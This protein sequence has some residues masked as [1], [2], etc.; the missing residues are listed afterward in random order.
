MTLRAPAIALGALA[1][2]AVAAC[3]NGGGLGSI[4]GSSSG[5]PSPLPSSAIGVAIPTGKI[6]VENDPVWGTVSGYT[7]DQTS[8]VL[9]FAPGAKVT[10]RNLSSTTPHTLNVIGTTNGPPPHWPASP[11]LPFSPR[12]N[13]ILGA[14]YA[15]GSLNPGASVTVTLSNPGIYLIGC[16]YHYI[17]FKMRDIIEVVAGATPGPTAS[18][19]PGGY[20]VAPAPKES[21][22]AR[23]PQLVDQSGRSFTLASLRGAP[24]VVT[25]I[26]AHCTDA[27]PLIN[28]QF[29]DAAQRIERA[30]LRMRLLTITLDPEHDSP[31]TMRG[32][33]QRFQANPRY[34]RL[35]GGSLA[36]VGALMRAFGVVSVEGQR[37][38]HD[39]HT[40]FV[41]VLD[42]AGELTRTML[43]SSALSDEIVGAA[44]D[45]RLVATR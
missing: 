45:D 43:A 16:A 3:T 4:G 20:A 21:P 42:A 11:S 24:L 13:G 39:E 23:E 9:A 15:S 34:W 28:A 37:G 6:G 18:P 40:T 1:V 25:F 26:A 8:Q 5:S 38:Y 31:R 10:I 19:G 14:T 29:S 27:C 22:A 35:A 41:Y 32:L 17:E 12:G 2:G 33:A 44:R 30:H 7:Q 36:D